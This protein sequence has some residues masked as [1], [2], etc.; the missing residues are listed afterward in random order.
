MRQRHQQQMKARAAHHEK[1]RALLTEEQRVIF[2]QDIARMEER[3]QG[4]M[5]RNDTPAMFDQQ[6]RKQRDKAQ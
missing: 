4:Y 2:D 3:M 6:K 5:Q 1:L